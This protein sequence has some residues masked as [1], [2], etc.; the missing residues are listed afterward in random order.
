VWTLLACSAIFDQICVVLLLSFQACV[1]ELSARATPVTM[2]PVHLDKTS[3]DILLF[4][5]LVCRIWHHFCIMNQM[6][7]RAVHDV[8]LS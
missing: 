2:S 5:L 6:P 1:G 8:V 3:G 7:P 4:T